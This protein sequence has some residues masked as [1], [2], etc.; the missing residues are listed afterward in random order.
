MNKKYEDDD[1]IQIDLLEILYAFRHRIWLI[2]L[3]VLLGGL[4]AGIYGR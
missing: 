2:L 1:E 3:A 4:A